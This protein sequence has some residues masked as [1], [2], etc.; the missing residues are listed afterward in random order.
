MKL[1]FDR[2]L[3]NDDEKLISSK[4]INITLKV[5]LFKDVIVDQEIY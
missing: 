1:N 2:A 3:K 5:G 4:I